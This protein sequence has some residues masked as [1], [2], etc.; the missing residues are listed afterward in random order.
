MSSISSILPERHF[1]EINIPHSELRA[2]SSPEITYRLR[3]RVNILNI[4][5][6]HLRLLARKWVFEDTAGQLHI[7]E[8]ER[9]FGSTPILA[10]RGVFSYGGEHVFARKPVHLALRFIGVD[11]LLMPFISTP[12]IFSAKQLS[13]F[14]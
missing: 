7:I 1:L 4:S 13:A 10:P 11:Q 14:H 2:L 9:V 12:F 5:R 6:V 8:A 3:F